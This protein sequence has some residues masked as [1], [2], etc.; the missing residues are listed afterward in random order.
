M[1][2]TSIRKISFE[3]VYVLEVK[4]SINLQI[5]VLQFAQQ[6]TTDEEELQG[7]IDQLIELDESKRH[8]FDQMA[9][10]QDKSKEAFGYKT[11]QRDFEEGDLVLMW[12]KM[13]E[14]P[15]MHT[16]FDSLWL[17]PYKIENIFGI[18]S[19]YLTTHEGRRLPLL[20]NVSLLKPFYVKGI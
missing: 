20:I 16:N 17:G 19:F 11:R 9:R 2:K 13:K 12:D 4:F 7:R 8:A 3:L 6:F 18:G 5:H 1:T 10:N 14:K 15:S